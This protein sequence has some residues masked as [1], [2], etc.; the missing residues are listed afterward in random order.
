MRSETG[1]RLLENLTSLFTMVDSSNAAP[2][3][4]M[5]KYFNEL[6]AEVDSLLKGPPTNN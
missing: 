4:A 6:D 2:T 3:A 1:P 5:V